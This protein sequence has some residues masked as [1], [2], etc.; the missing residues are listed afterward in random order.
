[1]LRPSSA[2]VAR[3]CPGFPRSWES[4]QD[5]ESWFQVNQGK[6]LVDKQT[7]APS[8]WSDLQ[9]SVSLQSFGPKCTCSISSG[10]HPGPHREQTSAFLGHLKIRFRV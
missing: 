10:S 1:M 5:L 9:F 6:V 4:Q 3:Q 2:E 7:R 8:R